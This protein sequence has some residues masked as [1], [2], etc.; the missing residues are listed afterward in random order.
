MNP[1]PRSLERGVYVHSILFWFS[2]LGSQA[3]D[4][5]A[6][7]GF[8]SP[9]P[10]PAGPYIARLLKIMPPPP[11]SLSGENSKAK[12]SGRHCV[13]S[14]VVGDYQFGPV[15]RGSPPLHAAPIYRFP[16]ETTSPP[17][18]RF[19]W[20][21]P[22]SKSVILYTCDLA[23]SSTASSGVPYA[24]ARPNFTFLHFQPAWSVYAPARTHTWNP[25]AAGLHSIPQHVALPRR[26]RR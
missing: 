4:P 18:G 15:L 8:I 20:E 12:L 9:V 21:Q 25:T 17:H 24:R 7:A 26:P 11:R 10:P 2:A 3:Q 19:F 1:G 5:A 13:V 6:R 23:S 22:S 16:V 14:R